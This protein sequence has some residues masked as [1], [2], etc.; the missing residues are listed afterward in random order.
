MPPPPKPTPSP[1]EKLGL[2]S[3]LGV[4][5]V[6]QRSGRVL[7]RMR[8]ECGEVR[9]MPPDRALRAVGHCGAQVHRI[10]DLTGS[11]FGRLMVL[12]CVGKNSKRDALWSCRCDCGSFVAVSSQGMKSGKTS[13]CG[14][15]KTQNLP[16]DLSG[17]RFGRLVAV[18]LATAGPGR[19]RW[20][21]LC[22]C[23]REKVT[24]A[25]LL[26]AGHTVSCGCARHDQPGLMPPSARAERAAASQSRR[27]RRRGAAGTFTA[28]EIAALYRKQRGRCACCSGSLKD[29]YHRDHRTPLALGG[30]N[31]IANIELLCGPCNLRKGAKDPVAWAAENGR[32]L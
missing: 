16:E 21:C 32:L 29:G 19:P 5:D 3:F 17:F 12:A 24:S 30:S 27:A 13:S 31:D 18:R 7:W 23:G 20:V 10:D 28:A 25:A 15:L 26:K 1:G 4:S 6:R 14:C 11:R 9:D 2:F 22:D 8:C